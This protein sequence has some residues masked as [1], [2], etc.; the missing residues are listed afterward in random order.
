MSESTRIRAKH[1]LR[2]PVICQRSRSSSRICPNID[3]TKY[4]IPL[5]LTIGQF[6]WVIRTRLQLHQ[7][8][9]LYMFT[10][11]IMP[12]VGQLIG[13]IYS[14]HKDADGFLY[15]YYNTENTFGYLKKVLS[16]VSISRS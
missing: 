10:N 3:K 14:I 15:L 16:K 8:M 2:I 9:A 13:S 11:G 6:I 4:L 12:P 1:P 5:D 7:S